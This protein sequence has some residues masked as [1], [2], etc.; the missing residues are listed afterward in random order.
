MQAVSLSNLL[1]YTLSTC[2]SVYA[3]RHHSIPVLRCLIPS[4]PESYP[5]AFVA[6]IF[7]QALYHCSTPCRDRV[8]EIQEFTPGRDVL[9]VLLQ[10]E[11]DNG[12][13]AWASTLADKWHSRYNQ[14]GQ[15]DWYSANRP[16]LS[17][18]AV[19]TIGH[20][21]MQPP[22][23]LKSRAASRIIW[24][25]WPSQLYLVPWPRVQR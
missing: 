5:A 15:Q 2:C 14:K 19:E 17:G 7:S 25:G 8:R 23:C 4:T 9:S 13:R 24:E 3:Q 6:P 18:V 12:T 22:W 10:Q 1:W 21:S 16:R 20:T 11:A